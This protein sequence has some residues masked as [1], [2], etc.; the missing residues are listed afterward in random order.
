MY[1]LQENCLLEDEIIRVVNEWLKTSNKKENDQLSLSLSG[2]IK[3]GKIEKDLYGVKAI[4]HC[5]CNGKAEL[6]FINDMHGN[7]INNYIIV[8]ATVNMIF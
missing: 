3:K 8:S 7:K 1:T 6:N 4:L 5:N 2:T